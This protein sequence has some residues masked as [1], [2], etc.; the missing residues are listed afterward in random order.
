VVDLAAADETMPMV[1]VV[2][3]T[4]TGYIDGMEDA[5]SFETSKVEKSWRWMANPRPA[6]QSEGGNDDEDD[7][8]YLQIIRAA[9]G[10]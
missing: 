5:A 10:E 8:D 3:R 2:D 9:E 6:D 1:G 4:E 7:G